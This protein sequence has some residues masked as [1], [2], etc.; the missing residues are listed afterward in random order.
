[1][2]ATETG[3]AR[4]GR[5][6][7]EDAEYMDRLNADMSHNI[8]DKLLN[9]NDNDN[10]NVNPYS[11]I[12][13]NSCFYNQESFI[14]KFSNSKCPL[15]LNLNIQS[16]NSKYE[17]LK[18]FI[19]TLTNKGIQIEIIAL[20]ETWKIK[21][22]QLLN[23][24]GFQPIIFKN[25]KFGRGGGVGFYLRNGLNHKII[26]NLSPTHDKLFEALTLDISY[27]QDNRTKHYIVTNIYRSPTQIAGMTT[28]QQYD[29]FN[30]NLDN[31]LNELTTMNADSYIFL[32]ANINLHNMDSDIQPRTYLANMTNNGF[33][34]TNTRTT[35]IQ[36][37]NFS[38]IDHIF[39]NT[40]TNSFTSGSIT[41]DIS[42]HFITFI[43]PNISRT[44]TKPTNIKKRQYNG[45]NMDNFKR[46]LQQ[47]SW[48]NV[49]T[50][51]DVDSA[52][53]AF[54]DTYKTL[55]DLHFPIVTT[56][57]NKNLHRI[58]DFMTQ[59]LLT[60][61][62]RK[63]TLHKIAITDNTPD[64]WLTY[65]TYRNYLN[66]L[67]RASK[68]MH[69]ET[70]IHDNARDPKKTW[71]ILK[72]MTTGKKDNQTI[73]KIIVNNEVITDHLTMA[74][75]FNTFFSQAG[76]K[77]Y[78]N[79]EPTTRQPCDYL[80]GN[81][82]P[83]MGIDVITAAKIIATIDNMEPKVSTDAGGVNMKM[84]KFLKLELVGPLVH[85]FNLSVTT[86]VFPTKLKVSRTIPV[87]KGGD[88][89][90]CDNYRPI[91]LLSSISKILEKI[92]S[93]SLVSHLEN[94]DLLYKNQYGFLKNRTTV[95]NIL[96]LT[97]RVARDLGEKKYVIG[98]FLDLRKAFDVVSHDILL[99]KLK[100]MG[101]NGTILNWFKSYLHNRQQYVDIQGHNST[102]RLIDISVIQGSIL[103]P[104]LFLC[105]INDLHL[106]TDMLSLLFADD[107][108]CLESHSDLPTLI[109]KVNLEI[110][111]LANW[112]RAN[113]MAVN[114]G[115]TKYIIFRPRGTKID[116]D[117]DNHGIV[118]NSNEIGQPDNPD[119]ITKLI[120]VHNDNPDKQSRTYKFLGLLLDEYLSFDDHCT[121]LCN[122]L[123]KSNF[124]IN[125]AKN[126]LPQ[127]SLKTLYFALVHPHL[128]YALPIFSCTSQKNIT[129]IFNM[130]KKAIR[131]ISKANHSAHTT[132]LFQALKIL[133]LQLLITFTKG[134]LMHSIYHKHSPLALHDTWTTNN[135]RNPDIDLRNGTDLF[136][137]LAR[138]DHVKKLP[139]FSLP[140]LWN[141]LPDDRLTYNKITFRIALKDHLHRQLQEE[142]Q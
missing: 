92:V 29:G 32:D 91:S 94:N 57:F 114:I 67:V 119:N 126:F 128:L 42:D 28:S 101:I 22:I 132:P 39:T 74:T 46:D 58:S 2:V 34:L 72:E 130:Q 142:T 76:K 103:G 138:T 125:R 8:M 60:S 7:G 37:G 100:K 56:K 98:V 121:S 109:N 47:L 33:L 84:I 25:R 4:T 81:N 44:K 107:T 10:D 27:T 3:A 105:F 90:S 59:G 1:M 64:N 24:P 71:D 16:L 15:F 65:R 86:G 122:K 104:I 113:R 17:K 82:V 50:T 20:Q 134:I 6:G 88:H 13:F 19:L 26:D 63:I 99:Q 135:L 77:I 120:R 43:Q 9:D 89:T 12:N 93:C 140:A 75:E 21:H 116:I 66:K 87:F 38:L 70:K 83:E 96:Q 129:A 52:Y 108:A 18:N 124:I 36:S 49:K 14:D 136:V 131:T 123:S 97:N 85:I 102:N 111:K 139:Y 53:D 5:G 23:I 51:T 133:P 118:Y 73:D 115:K 127:H 137:P 112:F 62:K 141:S 31:L 68:K 78:E 48:D 54:W 30:D 41:E 11:E 69:Y 110:Q 61:R 95:H 80:T 79:V 106:S 117:T 45:D 55:H 35:R 40:K